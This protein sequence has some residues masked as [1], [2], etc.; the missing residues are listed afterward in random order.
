MLLFYKHTQQHIVDSIKKQHPKWVTENG[1]CEKCLDFY[2]KKMG[3][4]DDS[5]SSLVNIGIGGAKKRT[6]LGVA[7]LLIAVG[8]LVMMQGQESLRLWRVVLFAP[9]F[10]SMLGFIQANQKVCVVMGAQGSKETDQGIRPLED[11][12]LEKALRV[13]SRRILIYSF[14]LA[15]LFTAAACGL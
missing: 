5:G 10:I 4:S 14:V 7:A 12:A 6:L 2:K 3:K 15:A 8:G 9:F 1:Y 13:V 11:Q